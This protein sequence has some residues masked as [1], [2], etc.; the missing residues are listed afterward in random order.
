MA[1]YGIV[2][3]NVPLGYDYGTNVD[4]VTDDVGFKY[5]DVDSNNSNKDV[6]MRVRAGQR[7]IQF[8]R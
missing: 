4:V 5:D 3:F 1:W 6:V 7:I 2:E 8:M